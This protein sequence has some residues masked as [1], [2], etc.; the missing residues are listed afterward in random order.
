VHLILLIQRK[1]LYLTSNHEKED[2]KMSRRFLTRRA[3]L[4]Y[5]GVTTGAM[6]L[7]LPW[8]KNVF[9]QAKPKKMV[10]VYWTVDGDEPAITQVNKLYATDTGIPVDWQRTPNIEEANQ[11]VLSFNLAKEQVDVF[12]MHYYNMAKWVK[13]GIVQPLDGF[14][15][16]SE[17]LKEMQPS[18]RN[19]VQYQGKTWGFPYFLSLNTNCYNT[20][21]FEKAGFKKLPA[22]LEELAEMAKKA[23]ADKVCDYPI[24]WQAGA[25]SEHIGDT[26][27]GLVAAA[28]GE[29]FDK[30]NNPMLGEGSI[31]RK[32]LKW[33]RD[34]IQEWKIADPSS[35]EL[36]WIPALKAYAAGKNI[37][38]NTRERYMLNANDPSKSPTAGI[39]K[40]F[41]IGPQTFAGHIW[42]LG[43]NAF[44]RDYSW[45]YLQY[46][47]GKTQ[48]GQYIMADARAKYAGASGWPE[49]TLANPEIK[50]LWNKW[51]DLEEYAR[52]WKDA[53]FIGDICRAMSTT[54]YL[55]WVDKTLV[56]N[57]Q[58][59]LAGKVT[60]DQA[61]DN[62]A[63]G[64]MDLKKRNP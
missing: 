34:T 38:T 63:K 36:R 42:A 22:T 14:S 52:Q 28:G 30:N 27:F 43:S 6:A 3:F 19:M 13:E 21:L 5:A 8:Q 53:K 50:A 44:D 26:Y 37:F 25:G 23:K 16:M 31:A 20:K 4:K 40:I 60:A 12:V 47:G 54:W 55:E 29:V 46:I 59:C 61:A 58:N 32:T 33:W 10:L 24:L 41:K 7:D 48:S 49:K 1:K 39:H 17:Y 18:A 57:L 15:G 56:P 35:L 51:F 45:R 2:A 62:I 64:A 11:K 9:A